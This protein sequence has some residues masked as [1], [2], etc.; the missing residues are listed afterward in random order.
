MRGLWHI[1]AAGILAATLGPA[2]AAEVLHKSYRVGDLIKLT[3]SDSV[4]W[5]VDAGLAAIAYDTNDEGTA[6]YIGTGPAPTRFVVKASGIKQ[7]ANGKSV[8]HVLQ[9]YVITITADGPV[10]PPNPPVPVPPAPTP[11]PVPPP[12][13][14]NELGVGHAVYRAAALVGDKANCVAAATSLS[15]AAVGLERSAGSEAAIEAS[16][17]VVTAALRS[18]MPSPKWDAARKQIEAAF[19]A[20][21]PAGGGYLTYVAFYREA[22]AGFAAAGK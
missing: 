11:N 18:A 3:A 9:R 17:K 21:L 19:N 8:P 10:P 5:D 12:D 1:T 20:A 4:G 16:A 14:P 15:N 6:C 22:A 2:H 7:L 13:V